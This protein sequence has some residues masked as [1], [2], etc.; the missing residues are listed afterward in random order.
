MD[1]NFEKIVDATQELG[2]LNDIADA[3][4]DFDDDMGDLG[5][6]PGRKSG[7]RLRR[8]LRAMQQKI[9]GHRSGLL[10][11]YGLLPTDLA[12]NKIILPGTIYCS[13][14][15]PNTLTDKNDFKWFHVGQ[16]DQCTD[17]GYTAVSGVDATVTPR[18]CNLGRTG[19]IPENEVFVN[20]GFSTML[21]VLSL[22]SGASLLAGDV[23]DVV[24]QQIVQLS[25]VLSFQYQEKNGTVNIPIGPLS[26]L[27]RV[28][29]ID[30]NFA[31]SQ[32]GGSTTVVANTYENNVRLSGPPFRFG[33]PI[34]VLRG[35]QGV[36]DRPVVVGTVHTAPLAANLAVG[37]TTSGAE[38]KV[39]LFVVMHGVWVRHRA[40]ATNAS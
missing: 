17:L 5:A 31:A 22:V 14:L 37:S 20:F 27:P 39:E 34:T 30:M 21:N 36:Q 11:K 32:S 9:K 38:N 26:H 12:G 6:N 15:L 24:A 13:R 18:L 40:R 10:T 28:Y 16:D 7:V 29:G 19:T 3:L 35:R 33:R 4:A 2:E 25:H 23:T 1:G 8:R